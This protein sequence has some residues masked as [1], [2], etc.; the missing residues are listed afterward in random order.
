MKFLKS[1]LNS[2]INFL[3]EY[4]LF[5]SNLKLSLHDQCCLT[6]PDRNVQNEVQDV[7]RKFGGK[8]KFPAFPAAGQRRKP[9]ENSERLSDGTG[10]TEHLKFS[11]LQSGNLKHDNL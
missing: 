7:V 11:G 6:F 8:F 1:L 9:P 4:V 10:Q 3:F 5:Y 2:A